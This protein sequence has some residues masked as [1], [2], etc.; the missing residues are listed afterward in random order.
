MS[1]VLVEP[2][3]EAIFNEETIYSLIEDYFVESNEDGEAKLTILPDKNIFIQIMD[4][5]RVD[6]SRTITS[7]LFPDSNELYVRMDNAFRL[8]LKRNTFNEFWEMWNAMLSVLEPEYL[9]TRETFEV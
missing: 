4:V 7:F 1:T 2:Q 9:M 5:D 6:G 8:S 3:K